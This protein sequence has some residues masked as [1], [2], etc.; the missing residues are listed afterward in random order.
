[1]IGGLRAVGEMTRL[2]LLSILCHGELNVS[3]LTQVLGQSQPRIS[4]HLR[5]MSDAGLLERHKEGS[6]VLFRVKEQGPEAEFVRAIVALLPGDDPVLAGDRMRLGRVF[7]T[8]R[9]LAMAYFSA[10]AARLGL[11]SLPARR[12]SRGR[13]GDGSPDRIAGGELLP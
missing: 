5:L 2:R 3:E 8:R 12:R 9:R 10:N 1:L 11:H 7:E 6:W 4:R 13:S